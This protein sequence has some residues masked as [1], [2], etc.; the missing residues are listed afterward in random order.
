MT[1]LDLLQHD[2]II[3][4]RKSTTNGGEFASPCPKCGGEDRFV[5][6]PQEGNGGRW[7]CRGCGHSGDP[8]EYLRHFRGL[9][10]P[11]A[12]AELGLKTRGN[13]FVRHKLLP[14]DRREKP[15][16]WQPEE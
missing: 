16:S 3:A 9:T 12:C 5:S 13:G 4:K 11:E 14:W 8:I 6:W 15:T 1:I 7:L 10:Y 2:G